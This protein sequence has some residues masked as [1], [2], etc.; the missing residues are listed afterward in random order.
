MQV[1]RCAAI[2]LITSYKQPIFKKSSS[3]N[4]QGVGEGE[5]GYNLQ[6]P[7]SGSSTRKGT[8]KVYIQKV[9][10]VDFTSE[11]RLS[12]M[13]LSMLSRSGG[14]PGIGGGFD[15]I[16][17]PVVGTFDHSSSPGGLYIPILILV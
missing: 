13:H 15:V 8:F 12:F 2:V 16:S 14:R 6:W 1:S 9:R 17:L 4:I 5:G 3:N 10:D 7:I 11:R